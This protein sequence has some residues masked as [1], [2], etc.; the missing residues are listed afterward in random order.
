ML[1]YYI[2]TLYRR[3]KKACVNHL[4]TLTPNQETQEN[5]HLLCRTA[6]HICQSPKISRGH[7]AFQP[8][9]QPSLF[10]TTRNLKAH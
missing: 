7:R 4:L 6:A 3:M 2:T 5:P 8:R 9:P 1:L 10:G